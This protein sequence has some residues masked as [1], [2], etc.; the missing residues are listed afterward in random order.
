MSNQNRRAGESANTGD[1]D[2]LAP[3]AKQSGFIIVFAVSA[4]A[5]ALA[6]TYVY[7]EK[8][9]S[10]T[11]ISY[12]VQEVT[13][14]RAQQNEAMGSPA[15]AA[16]FKVI[17]QTLQEVLK[18]DAILRDVVVELKLDEK[19]VSTYDGPWYQ[20]WYRK[21]RDFAKEYSGYAWKLLKYGRIVEDEPVAT[22]IAELRNN[23]KVTNRDSYV[24]N[25]SVRDNYPDR[26][27]KIADHLGKVLADWLLEF[28]RQPGRSR[29]DQL[30]LL[31]DDKN[32]AMAQQR[33]EIESLLTENRVASVPQET[34]RLTDQLY[35]LKLEESRLASELARADA[36]HTSVQSKLSIKQRILNAPVANV[37]VT[38]TPGL[39]TATTS[40]PEAADGADFIQP[41]DFKKLA[42]QGLF[43]D[44]DS[45]SLRAK[46]KSLVNSI[47]EI[48]LRLRRLPV[49]QGRLDAMKLSLASLERDFALLNDGYQEAA[50]RAT[51]PVSEVIVL[52]AA[53]IPTSP[54]GPIKVY[55]VLLAGG[56]GL[57]FALGLVY[58][59]DFLNVRILFASRGPA[60]RTP[61]AAAQEPPP[62]EEPRVEIKGIAQNG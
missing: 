7:S 34:E 5:T 23:I 24:F 43:D 52:H 39:L 14:F 38:G 3:L 47:D 58:L 19:R 48:N 18:S 56:L 51:S 55:Y 46:H 45:S 62:V 4:I 30:R 57:L 12:R 25:L 27:A 50:V 2:F 40:A 59:L 26:A 53:T 44:I 1:P 13:R 42:S 33:K 8:Y 35:A 16:P 22:A 20:V 41:D 31:L 17:G 28:D 9:E 32:K 29:A 37:N 60:W 6:L 54:V 10:S 21:T 49:V 61:L 36:R 11:A 15:P